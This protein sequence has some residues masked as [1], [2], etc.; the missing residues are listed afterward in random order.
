MTFVMK[1]QENEHV[2]EEIFASTMFSDTGTHK[3]M[4]SL[5]GSMKIG[6]ITE[7]LKLL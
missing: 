4:D 5:N 2:N 6:R 7:L 1:I 3:C